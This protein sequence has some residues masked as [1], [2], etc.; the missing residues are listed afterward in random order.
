[1]QRGSGAKRKPAILMCLC[2]RGV[3]DAHAK[4]EVE[5][6]RCIGERSVR[7]YGPEVVIWRVSEAAC[8][9]VTAA[10]RREAV[11]SEVSES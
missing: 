7:Q 9:M 4:P 1:V 6:G 5:G 11:C 3:V 8:Q 2:K 10:Q